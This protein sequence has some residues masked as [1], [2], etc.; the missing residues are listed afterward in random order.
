MR[1]LHDIGK[2][3][4]DWQRL[5][6]AVLAV[7]SKAPVKNA[8]ALKTLGE[9]PVRLLSDENYVNARRFHSYD[10]F[11]EIELHSTI[12]IDKTGRVHWARTGGE[13]FSDMA[14]LVKQLERM[15]ASARAES[16]I[17]AGGD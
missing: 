2:K 12:L 8:E 9:L 7:S 16:G 11:E 13:P 6:T 17:K 14:F 5:D 15:N 4:D 1:Q 10:D 3:K